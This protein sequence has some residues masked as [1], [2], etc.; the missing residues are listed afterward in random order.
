MYWAMMGRI[1]HFLLHYLL[2]LFLL[3]LVQIQLKK[4]AIIYQH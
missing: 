1:I 2:L 3:L 4:E